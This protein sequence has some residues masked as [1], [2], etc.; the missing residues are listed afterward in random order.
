MILEDK[1]KARTEEL[2][3]MLAQASNTVTAFEKNLEIAKAQTHQIEGGINELRRLQEKKPEAKTP[4]KK[5]KRKYKKRQAAETE[6]EEEEET[7]DEEEEEDVTEKLEKME[8]I[9]D[10]IDEVKAGLAGTSPRRIKVL[11]ALDNGDDNAADISSML[12]ID[13]H[14][15][16]DDLYNLAK[17]GFAQLKER[18]KYKI[19][20]KGEE[21]LKHDRHK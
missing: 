6:T 3:R 10:G 8:K 18:G 11:N 12:S 5:P 2:S 1:I 7:E 20:P 9:Q 14:T 4:A 17:K 19:T 15:I 13:R 16:S 21:A